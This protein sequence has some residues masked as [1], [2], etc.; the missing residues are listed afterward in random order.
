[1]SDD[2]TIVAVIGGREA[3]YR[4]PIQ[5]VLVR[6]MEAYR[7]V[8]ADVAPADA[9]AAQVIPLGLWWD[10]DDLGVAPVASTRAQWRDLTADAAL[11]YAEA[12]W[13]ALSDRGYSEGEIA[14]MAREL[15]SAAAESVEESREVAATVDFGRAPAA[16]ESSAA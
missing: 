6:Q 1:L 13:S 8:T 11:D 15:V 3:R 10:G 16:G 2:R 14:G 12:V 9:I 5:P 4:L 7:R